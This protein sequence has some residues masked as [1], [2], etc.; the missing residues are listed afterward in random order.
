[1]NEN[2]SFSVESALRPE[3]LNELLEQV[4]K[5]H[6][7]LHPERFQNIRRGVVG[8]KAAVAFTFIGP[9]DG[10]RLEVEVWA[11]QGLQV[12]TERPE[13]VPEG[14]VRWLYDDLLA[15]V[16]SIEKDLEKAS[17]TLIWVKGERI[18]P[19]EMPSVMRRSFGRLFSRSLLLLNILLFAFNIILFILIGLIA[20]LFILLVQLMLIIFADV[21]FGAL[22]KW[23][24]TSASPQVYLLT[25]KVDRNVVDDIK[26]K[27]VDLAL[28]KQAV[29]EIG[30]R[31]GEGT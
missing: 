11:E 19:E 30:L 16:R 10:W 29:F 6:L 3:Q 9:P 17:I 27:K 15:V 31:P 23:T 28:L 8:G 5:Y 12:R 13:G 20:V 7:L 26:A 18:V 2:S 21:L 24:I 14:A 1:M 25:I 22:G 4:R